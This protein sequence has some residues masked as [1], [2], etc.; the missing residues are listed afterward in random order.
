[1][2]TN[3]EMLLIMKRVVMNHMVYTAKMIRNAVTIKVICINIIEL[4][5]PKLIMSRMEEMISIIKMIQMS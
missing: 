5:G 4:S 1:M 2:S 3:L